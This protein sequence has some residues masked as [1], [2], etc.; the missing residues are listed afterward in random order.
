M[1]IKS[2]SNHSIAWWKHLVAIFSFC[3]IYVMGQLPLALLIYQRKEQLNISDSDF[4]E[5]LSTMDLSSL[6]ISENL[7]FVL[8]LIPFILLFLFFRY[9]LPKLL[10]KPFLTFVTHRKEFDLN[11]F[12]FASLLWI[13]LATLLAWLFMDMNSLTFQF[14]PIPFLILCVISLCLLPIQ[15]TIEELVF[16]GYFLQLSYSIT[17]NKLVSLL[18]VTV[19]FGAMHLANPEFQHNFLKIM[20][21]YLLLSLVF[22]VIAI[23]DDGLE[24]PMGLHAGNNIFTA[25]LLSTS[26]GAMKTPSLFRTEMTYLVD[27]LPLL[28]G[29]LSILT[30]VILHLKYKWNYRQLLY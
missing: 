6:A 14:R 11:R 22:G 30:M 27:V 5:R 24:L 25:L 21:S 26:D 18:I 7:L 23:I 9:G 10:N 15:T 19:G 12:F 1:H 13:T 17:Q 29:T 28:L 2:L 16:R 8:I 3:G 20:S 4:E